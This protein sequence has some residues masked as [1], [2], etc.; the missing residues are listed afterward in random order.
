A[1][2]GVSG[3][4]WAAFVIAAAIG[5]PLRLVVDDLV[6]RRWAPPLPWGTFL[7][8]VSGSLLLGLITGLALYHGLPKTPRLVLGTGFCGAYT[9]F[10]TFAFETVR[11]AEEGA[12]GKAFA[13]AAGSVVAGTLAAAAGLAIASL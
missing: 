6:S 4:G 1:A 12:P 7:V 11:L 8:N 9:T 13:N 3:P 10:S 2:P 5:A